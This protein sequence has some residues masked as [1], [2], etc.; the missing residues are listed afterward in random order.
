MATVRGVRLR[1]VLPPRTVRRSLQFV[2]AYRDGALEVLCDAWHREAPNV[3][4][5]EAGAVAFTADAEVQEAQRASR[6][7]TPSSFQRWTD[8]QP[9]IHEVGVP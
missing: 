5:D 7:P 2:V 9:E 1:R 4:R 6:L 8:A 3:R